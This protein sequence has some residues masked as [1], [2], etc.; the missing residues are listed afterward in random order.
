ML[1]EK[2]DVRGIALRICGGVGVWLH[3]ENSR[4]W[5]RALGRE[6]KDVDC[7][8]LSTDIRSLM[9]LLNECGYREDTYTQRFT[10]QWSRRF[11]NGGVVIDAAIDRLVYCHEIDLRT[12]LELDR[13]TI[14]VADLLLSKLQ[15]VT[16]TAADEMDIVALCDEH[17]LGQ[18]MA[19]E[20][21]DEG[22]VL[23]VLSRNWGFYRTASE[24]L[25]RILSQCTLVQDHPQA[26]KRIRGLLAG[27]VKSPKS[28]RWRLRRALGERVRWYTP[29]D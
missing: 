27:L 24:N 2:A 7:V 8:C 14:T 25:N 3:C 1:V 13:P 15:N 26:G 12:R 19:G 28:L 10:A 23:S 4:G 11:V 6:H 5:L 16:M 21:I 17:P 29:V 22:R 20:T 9:A 18:H